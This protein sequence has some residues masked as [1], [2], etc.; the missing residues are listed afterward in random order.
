MKSVNEVMTMVFW[1]ARKIIRIDY[2]KKGQMMNKV[3]YSSLLH[4]L[5]KEI[6]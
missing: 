2:R 4:H 6:K 1:D 5:S 3:Y